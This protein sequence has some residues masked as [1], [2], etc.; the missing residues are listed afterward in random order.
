MNTNPNVRNK[1]HGIAL[2]NYRLAEA[3]LYR[4]VNAEA[5]SN[6]RGIAYLET[7]PEYRGLVA[8]RDDARAEVEAVNPAGTAKK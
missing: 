1:A 8:A 6:G 3:T 7:Q 5:V 2:E 4:A